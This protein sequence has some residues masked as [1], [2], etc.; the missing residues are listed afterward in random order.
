LVFKSCKAEA[1]IF[2]ETSMNAAMKLKATVMM[3]MIKASLSL[4][5]GKRVRDS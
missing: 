2:E 1:L 3:V 5:T 4:Y